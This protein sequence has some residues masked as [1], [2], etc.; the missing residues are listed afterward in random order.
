MSERDVAVLR[1][2]LNRHHVSP[3]HLSIKPTLEQE[4]AAGPAV[5]AAAS[6]DESR[7]PDQVCRRVGVDQVGCAIESTG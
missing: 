1:C 7:R 2:G 3:A 6:T 5:A 4:K